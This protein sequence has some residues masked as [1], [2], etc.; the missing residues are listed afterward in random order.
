MSKTR[1]V[2]NERLQHRIRSK[3]ETPFLDL[4]IK[5]G[6]QNTKPI[7]NGSPW[8]INNFVACDR[9]FT[10]NPYENIHISSSHSKNICPEC[11]DKR[12]HYLSAISRKLFD[13]VHKNIY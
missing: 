8:K 9:C 1:N 10:F 7:S 12:V 11:G 6:E 4:E 2:L 13:Y 5:K 3:K